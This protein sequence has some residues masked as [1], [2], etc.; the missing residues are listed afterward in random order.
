MPNLGPWEGAF[1]MLHVLYSRPA[2]ELLPAA[3]IVL[4]RDEFGHICVVESAGG[5]A[6]PT[7]SA[8]A[9]FTSP[10]PHLYAGLDATPSAPTI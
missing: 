1:C 8:Q 5:P 6:T 10:Q 3:S 4:K 9:A 2:D 7:D